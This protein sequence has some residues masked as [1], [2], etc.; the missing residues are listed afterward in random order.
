MWAREG[1][2]T[3]G[4]NSGGHS[5]P[6]ARAIRCFK[7]AVRFTTENPGASGGGTA[8]GQGCK[9]IPLSKFEHMSGPE[10]DLTLIGGRV[11]Q[12]GLPYPVSGTF[13]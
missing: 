6:S 8:V 3:G 1:T 13:G 2:G 7:L 11:W 12:M 9:L 5:A 10:T 4:S